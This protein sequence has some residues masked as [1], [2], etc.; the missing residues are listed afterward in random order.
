MSLEG[1]VAVVTGAAHGLGRIHALALAAR[2]ARVV[3]NDLG[4]AVDGSGRDGEPAQAGVSEIKEAGGEAMAHF[5]DVANWDSAQAMIQA[6]VESFGDLHI[7]VNNAGFTR[8]A[9][10]FN[11]T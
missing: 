1:K 11:M 6:A 5:G 10:L 2:G 3:V 9:T 8:D 7:L 4:A